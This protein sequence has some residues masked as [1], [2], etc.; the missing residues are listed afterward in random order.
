[1]KKREFKP[2]QRKSGFRD[3]NLIIIAAEGSNT[4]K[5]YFEA[6][7][8]DIKYRNPKVH[9]E[10]LVREETA[11]SPQHVLEAMN[12]F[13]RTYSLSDDDLLWLVIDVDRWKPQM[14][15]EVAAQCVQKKFYLAVSNPSFEVWL[16]MHR[17]SL[18]SFTE[19]E[20][21]QLSEN[22]KDGSRTRLEKALLDLC[23]RYDK[24]RLNTDDYIPFVE[25]A[26]EHART[27]D[28]NPADRW[29]QTIGTRV[30]LLA[31]SIIKKPV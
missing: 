25:K 20:I 23:G 21:K 14:L 12:Q 13:K 30:Y 3:A 4:E 10:I 24:T 19:E 8:K 27:S 5:H 28:T 9:V 16:L 17:R 15:S 26:I 1:M 22:K 11:S 2:L 31:E 29:P 18:D 6:L 7:S